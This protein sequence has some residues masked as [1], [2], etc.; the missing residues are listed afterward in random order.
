LVPVPVRSLLETPCSYTWRIRSS[1]CCMEFKVAVS[2]FEH[3]DRMGD[4]GRL[5]QH[6]RGRAVFIVRQSHGALNGCLRQI[7]AGDSEA[8]MDARE[9]L[10]VR[11]SAVCFQADLAAGDVMAT[12][13]ENEHDIIG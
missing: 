13:L 10:G 4:F 3:G 11:F 6:G 7:A 12:A 9:N 5:R 8:E 1:Y 2:V